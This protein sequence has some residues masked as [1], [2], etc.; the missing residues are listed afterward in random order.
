MNHRAQVGASGQNTVGAYTRTSPRSKTPCTEPPSTK[1]SVTSASLRNTFSVVSQNILH[2]P[3]V[4]F[5][6]QLNPEDC[7]AGPRFVLSIRICISVASQFLPISPPRAST[8]L[9]KVAY[10][11]HQYL[12]YRAKTTL[13]RFKVRIN[14]RRPIRAAAELLPLLHGQHR[15]Q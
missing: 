6:I 11:N 8:S 10:R 14:T 2:P 3:L 7:T 4:Q 15:P 12:D 5:P 1:R 9:T 13:S